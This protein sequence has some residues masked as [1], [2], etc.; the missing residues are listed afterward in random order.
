[1][2]ELIIF[3]HLSVIYRQFLLQDLKLS[4][5]TALLIKLIIFKTC[6]RGLVHVSLLLNCKH[7]Q[8]SELIRYWAKFPQMLRVSHRRTCVRLCIDCC[9]FPAITDIKLYSITYSCSDCVIS[10]CERSVITNH[11]RPTD[12]Y[13]YY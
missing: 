7:G 6:H 9:V 12:C 3:R 5:V 4:S 8:L 11:H 2:W 1:M 13:Y 10:A